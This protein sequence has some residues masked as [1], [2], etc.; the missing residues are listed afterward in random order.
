[1]ANLPEGDWRLQQELDFRRVLGPALAATRGYASE[2]VG[3]NLAQASALAERLGRTEN[4]FPLRYGQWAF[5]LVRAEHK[6]ALPLAEQMEQIGQVHNDLAVMLL[7]RWMHG[8][9]RLFLGEFIAARTLFEQSHDLKNPAH[10]AKYV[11]LPDDPHTAMLAH[12]ATALACL[13]HVDQARSSWNEALSL[14]RRLERAFTVVLV[15]YYACWVEWLTASPQTAQRLAEEAM[16]VSDEHG[17]NF[18]LGLALSFRGWSLSASGQTEEGLATLTKALSICRATG[19]V[20]TTPLALILLAEVHAQLGRP[21]E[22]LNCLAEAAQ[23]VEVTEERCDESELHR[24]RGDLLNAT[25]HPSEAE[26]NYHQALA[27]ARRQSAKFL[28]LRAATGLARLWRDQGKRTEARDVLAAIY[29][30]FT[31]GF[32]TPVLK[33]AKALLDQLT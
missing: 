13:G 30:W 20:V 28:E 23:I 8:L 16:A 14:A 25:G 33:E 31:E 4:L 22:G 3:E 29:N 6:L 2:A 5:H 9:S 10:R 12:L 15:L 24:L 11:A 26:R 7:G 17:F 21:V 27:V 32:D 1:M 18:W 19:A